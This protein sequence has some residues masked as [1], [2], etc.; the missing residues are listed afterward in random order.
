MRLDKMLE[1]FSHKDLKEHILNRIHTI[2]SNKE[3][4]TLLFFI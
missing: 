3:L 1:S 2:D 4:F